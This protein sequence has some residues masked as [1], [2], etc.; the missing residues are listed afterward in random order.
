M[1][2]NGKII[3][4][5]AKVCLLRRMEIN[6]MDSGFKEERMDM[7]PIYK[8]TNKMALS[9]IH[10]VDNGSMAKSKEKGLKYGMM[11]QNLKAIMKMI[12]NMVKGLCI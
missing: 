9:K 7:L 2:D 12:K 4:Q 8:T 3:C 6:L 1:R 10:T 11:E 5:M